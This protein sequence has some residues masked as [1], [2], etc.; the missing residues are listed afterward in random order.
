MSGK[1]VVILKNDA[2]G[3]LVH[4]LEAINNIVN[5]VEIDKITIYIS[6]LSKKFDFLFK[7]SKVNIKVLNYN[8]T[9][10]EKVKIFNFILI[11]KI[12]KVYILSPK[13][14]YYLLPIFFLKTKFYAICINNINGYKRPSV[15]LRKFL[16]KFEINDRA[17]NFK[18]NSTS[19]IQNE[20]TMSKNVKKKPFIIKTNFNNELTK[21]IPKNYI[22]F[23][24]KRKILNELEWGIDEL[25]LLFNEF[26]KKTD[27]VI[28]TK[29]IEYDHNNEIFKHNFNSY[30]LKTYKFIDKSKKVLFLDNIDGVDL[31]NV[32]RNSSRI[33]AFHGMMTNIGS[34]NKQNILDLFHCNIKNWNDYRNYR[35]SFYE[36]KPNYPGYN[37]I[38]PSKNINK[39]IRKMR[40]FLI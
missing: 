30:D 16:Y 17:A 31:Y 38:I 29:D 1:H 39:T 5:D 25:K 8:L 23:H 21:F 20:L 2:V 14:F 33:V 4:S 27:F 9:I 18:R 26:L 19:A 13:R 7:N 37:F 11:N 3:D 24:A 35:N 6:K 40:Y 12:Y 36:F 22:Y 28:L 15:F 10:F 34:I 32:I